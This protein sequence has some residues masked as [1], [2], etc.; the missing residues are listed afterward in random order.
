MEQIVIFSWSEVSEFANRQDVYLPF[1][2]F[3]PYP[4][5]RRTGLQD[6]IKVSLITFCIALIIWIHIFEPPR[7]AA[8]FHKLMEVM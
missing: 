6:L 8:S 5:C 4:I 1:L 2:Q 7:G 3:M